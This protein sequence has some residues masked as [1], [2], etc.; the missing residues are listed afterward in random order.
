MD[1]EDWRNLEDWLQVEIEE[2]L[3]LEINGRN[4]EIN[5]KDLLVRSKYLN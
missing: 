2:C 1:I 3:C 5:L 4:S